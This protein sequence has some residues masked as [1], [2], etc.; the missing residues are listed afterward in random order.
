M[1]RPH[2]K[3]LRLWPTARDLADDLGC[4]TNAAKTMRQRGKIASAHW[5]RLVD[6]A[7]RRGIAGVTLE[8]LAALVAAERAG[9]DRPAA[10]PGGDLAA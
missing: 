2:A 10:R 7:R 9:G 6:G 5:L 8:V 3:L 1:D 4:C